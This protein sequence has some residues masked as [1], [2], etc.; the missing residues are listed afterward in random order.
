[1]IEDVN[2]FDILT[3]D[4]EKSKRLTLC[5][6]CEKNTVILDVNTCDSCACPIEYVTT[7]KFK[8]CPL[9]KWDINEL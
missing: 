9:N 8:S 3:T 6:S 1:M 4:E 2:N 7:Y 5:N